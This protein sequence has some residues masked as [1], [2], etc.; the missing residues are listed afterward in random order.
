MCIVIYLTVRT[1]CVNQ[2]KKIYMKLK[3]LCKIISFN[4]IEKMVQA[5]TSKSCYFSVW[6]PAEI[7]FGSE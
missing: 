7:L 2:K 3:K 5:F 6:L 4:G 1:N